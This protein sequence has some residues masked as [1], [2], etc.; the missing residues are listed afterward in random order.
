MTGSV[1]RR[2]TSS[3]QLVACGSCSM[4]TKAADCFSTTRLKRNHVL[5]GILRTMCSA[6]PLISTAISL[7]LPFWSK[8]SATLNACSKGLSF[9]L[10][11]PHRIQSNLGKLTPPAFPVSS[12]K[13]PPPSTKSQQ[14]SFDACAKRETSAEVFPDDAMLL[15]QIS[16]KACKGTPCTSE[17]IADTPVGMLP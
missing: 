5:K 1:R 13:E 14:W 4:K 11:F 7:K 15:L 9:A 2:R 3:A 17:S 8:I 10:V 6:I 16:V 12:Y